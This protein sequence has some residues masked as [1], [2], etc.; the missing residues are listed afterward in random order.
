MFAQHRRSMFLFMISAAFAIAVII[1]T[2]KPACAVYEAFL[3]IECIPGE[4]L[5]K[6]HENQIDI[7][8][9][10]F[11]A[12]FPA[13][14]TAA[15]KSASGKMVERD[16]RFT[17]KVNRASPKLFR[18]F[19]TGLP[20]GSVILFVQGGG[21]NEKDYL[22]ITLGNARVSS[23]QTTGDPKGSDDRPID[24]VSLTF[25]T[26]KIDYKQIKPNGKLVKDSTWTECDFR[27]KE[28]RCN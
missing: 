6:G 28:V 24:T 21:A 7:L 13:M 26:I 5:H 23:F 9:W 12:R 1:V 11:D 18:A 14:P 27:K 4:S 16:F 2:P 19:A 8:S 20:L 22:V 17:M 25:D 15:R 10:S 3:S